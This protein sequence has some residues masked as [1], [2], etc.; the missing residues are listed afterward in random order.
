MHTNDIVAPYELRNRPLSRTANAQVE[1]KEISPHKPL[2]PP[3]ENPDALKRI[4]EEQSMRI[5]GLE[6]ERNQLRMAALEA[7]YTPA[8]FIS[9]D[10]LPSHM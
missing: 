2:L 9:D 8:A 10:V 5:V 7:A 3:V 1:L 4:I 6:N